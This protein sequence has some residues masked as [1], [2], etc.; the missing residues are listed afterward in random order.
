[1]SDSIIDINKVSVSFLQKGKRLDAVKDVSLSINSGDI[2][3]IVGYSGAGKSTL[4]RTINLLQK[5]TSGTVVVDNKTFFDSSK[6]RKPTISSKELRIERQKIGM[7][8]QHFNLL[9]EQTVIQNVEFALKHSKL[10]EKQVRQRAQKLLGLVGLSEYADTYPAQLSGGQQQRVAIARALANDPKILISDEST[11]AL[12]PQNTNQILD[13][14]KRL[15]LQLGLTVILITHEID[16]VKRIANKAAVMDAG[17]IIES[18]SIVDVFVHPQKQLTKT[19]IGFNEGPKKAISIL[20]SN[21]LKLNSN[22]QYIKL[23]Y[24]GNE[25]SE[26]VVI[27]LYKDLD[28]TANIIYSDVDILGDTLV[29]MMFII[30]EGKSENVDKAIDY[31]RQR[32]INIEKLDR[33]EVNS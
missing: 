4:S 16:A 25:V 11:S 23:T 9:N 28:V 13:L 15:N 1:M 7:I 22:E 33:S 32:N 12:D 3:G 14:L 2:Y 31:L 26:P 24:F 18:G 27:S 10:K 30:I 29:G 19:L 17:Q 21:G 20:N 6:S 8:F 5:P